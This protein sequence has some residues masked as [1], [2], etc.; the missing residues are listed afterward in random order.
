MVA[1]IIGG[2]FAVVGMIGI[3]CALMVDRFS[4]ERNFIMSMISLIVGFVII[5]FVGFSH[6]HERIDDCEAKGGTMLRTMGSIEC[7]EI[8]RVE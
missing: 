3:V 8:R 6:H 7:F 4:G 5:A 2:I 1:M